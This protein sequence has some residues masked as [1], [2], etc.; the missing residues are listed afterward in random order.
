MI[1]W[2]KTGLLPGWKKKKK[3]WRCGGGCG[4]GAVVGGAASLGGSNSPPGITTLT[5]SRPTYLLCSYVTTGCVWW[6][7]VVSVCSMQAGSTHLRV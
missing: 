2:Q 5:E 4:G 1:G 3:H 7:L 6:L